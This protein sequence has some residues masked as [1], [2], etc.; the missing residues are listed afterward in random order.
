MPNKTLSPTG[1]V[2]APVIR[3]TYP[4]VRVPVLLMCD[5]AEDRT[6]QSFKDECNINFLMKRYEK[7]GVLPVGRQTR[8]QYVDAT[9]INFQSAMERVAEV[10][11]VFSLLD[12]K[13]RKRFENDPEQMLE[14]LADPSN[15]EEARR[16]G[17]VAPEEA[18][19]PVSEPVSRISPAPVSA[20]AP[21]PA[22]AGAAGEAASSTS[23]T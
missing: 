14:F 15:L 6:Q 3:A 8:P 9:V 4:F 11:G 20:P 16:L 5:P 18:P 22:A 1:A 7:T 10:R 2:Q 19:K 23:P 17:L 13:T 21:A 12:A